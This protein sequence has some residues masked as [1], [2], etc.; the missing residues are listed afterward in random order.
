MN[1]TSADDEFD[2]DALIV[3]GTC[4]DLEKDYFRLTSSPDPDTVRPAPVL[5]QAL[6][7]LK[8]RWGDEGDATEYLWV[9]SQ[10]SCA[11]VRHANHVMVPC[12]GTMSWYVMA[13]GMCN[14]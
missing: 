1:N 3:R 12:H 7:H 5:A 13:C 10:V 8:G 4:R 14:V 11:R 2:P 9:C 6:A